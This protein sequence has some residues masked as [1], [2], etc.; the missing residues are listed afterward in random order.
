MFGLCFTPT[1]LISLYGEV[2]GALLHGGRLDSCSQG[3][4]AFPPEDF[5]DLVCRTRVTILNQTSLVLF[6][7]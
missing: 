6:G 1:R 2:W 4:S 5:Y 3:D 7:N